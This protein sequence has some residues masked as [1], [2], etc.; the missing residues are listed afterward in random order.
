[1]FICEDCIENYVLKLPKDYYNI[2]YGR[3]EDCH[4]QKPC[5]D[6]VHNHYYHKESLWAKQGGGFK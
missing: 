1:M 2:S 3:C 6:V 4:Q 5:R